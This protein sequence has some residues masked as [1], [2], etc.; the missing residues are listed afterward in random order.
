VLG[1]DQF[2]ST[3][4]EMIWEGADGSQVLGILFANWY[5]NGNEIPVDEE[6]ARVFW[7]KKLADVRKYA[8]TS[9]YL[10][11]NGCDHQPV[12]KNLSQ[13]LRLAR[14]LYPDIDFVH[15]SFEEY[16][17]AVKEELPKDLSRVKGELISQETDGWYTLAN[18][19][20]SRIYLKQANDQAS[21][22]LE[23]VVEPLVVMTG[24][25]VP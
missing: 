6:E 3:F 10:L 8:S 21:Q 16:I 9:H 15:S 25:K 20:S 4:S 14:K 12:Q 24:D 5:S 17:A 19:A 13:A 23:Q 1:D 7:E 18:T 2:Q 11:M 22:L